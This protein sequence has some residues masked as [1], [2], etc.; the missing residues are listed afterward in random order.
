MVS[1]AG[2]FSA[3]DFLFKQPISAEIQIQTNTETK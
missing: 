1:P 3:G 2:I